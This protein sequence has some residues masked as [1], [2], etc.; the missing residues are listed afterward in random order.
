[1]G[2]PMLRTVSDG[3]A[4]R[5]VREARWSSLPAAP[6]RESSSGFGGS[7][8]RSPVAIVIAAML[9][10]CSGS[11]GNPSTESTTSSHMR[12]AFVRSC[13][14]RVYGPLGRGW[15]SRSVVVGPIA[16]VGA[17]GYE[18]YRPRDLVAGRRHHTVKVLVVVASGETVIVKVAPQAIGRASLAYDPADFDLER[19]DRG[20]SAV[21]FSACPEGT[22]LTGRSG[23]QFNGGIVVSKPGCIPLLVDLADAAAPRRSVLSVGG[24]R[25]TVA[26]AFAVELG[27]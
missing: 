6:E 8:L 3:G 23:T 9:G 27:A 7:W 19:V 2:I 22:T 4:V 12:D 24:G 25:C 1:M 18:D 17:S 14:S 16:F 13:D 5:R 21:R 10:A 20:H 26:E 15:R 11:D